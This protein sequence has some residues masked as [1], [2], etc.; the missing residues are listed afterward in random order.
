MYELHTD[1]DI[2]AAPELVWV[3]LTD[4]E[5]YPRWNPFIRHI[6]G[7]PEA[8]GTLRVRIEPRGR[9]GITIRPT[10]LIADRGRDCAGLAGC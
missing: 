3:I 5:S 9:R 10:V 1:I 4:F 6:H 2:A 7:K 8:G